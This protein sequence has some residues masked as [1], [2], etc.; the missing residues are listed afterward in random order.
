MQLYEAFR[1]DGIT[2][3]AFEG[4]RYRRIGQIK[5]LLAEGRLDEQLRFRG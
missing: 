2:L 4:W 3:E 5:R 1:R